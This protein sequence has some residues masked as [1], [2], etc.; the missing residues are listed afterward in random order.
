MTK[1]D[2]GEF[3]YNNGTFLY[4]V[5]KANFVTHAL[6]P[7]HKY[8][9]VSLE[10]DMTLDKGGKNALLGLIC[11]AEATSTHCRRDTNLSVVPGVGSGILEQT[12]ENASDFKL[13]VQKEQADA[14]PTSGT[15]HLR[16]D[17]A[18]DRFA[19]YVNGNK[20][21]EAT[22]SDLKSGQVGFAVSSPQNEGVTV[23]FDNFVVREAAP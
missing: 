9:N 3:S 15:I 7:N 8:D 10:A 17:C 23:R 18:G 1:T 19:L 4:A 6:L 5:D 21:T 16:A 14:I 12:G 2:Y 20:L 11:R 13:L 22:N